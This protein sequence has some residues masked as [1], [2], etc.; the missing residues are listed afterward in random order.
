MSKGCL[1]GLI[2]LGFFILAFVHHVL[3]Q[4][5]GTGLIRGFILGGG[6][7][8]LFKAFQHVRKQKKS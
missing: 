3:S 8:L 2:V 4:Q 6:V 1:Y 7:A 5:E